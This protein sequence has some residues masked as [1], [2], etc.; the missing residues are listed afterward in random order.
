MPIEVD[1][2]S[3]DLARKK[4]LLLA[5]CER[6]GVITGAGYVLRI[7]SFYWCAMVVCNFFTFSIVATLFKIQQGLSYLQPR[8][9]EKVILLVL[10]LGHFPCPQRCVCKM[11]KLLHLLAINNTYPLLLR[12]VTFI[13]WLSWKS[14][15]V[16]SEAILIIFWRQCVWRWVH[17]LALYIHPWSTTWPSFWYLKSR[18]AFLLVKWAG[19]FWLRCH[20]LRLL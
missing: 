20:L 4:E 3:Y 1:R 12:C 13:N 17:K 8:I 6:T 9:L 15:R 18:Y 5:Q 10:I 19:Y 7:V 2:L 14:Y 16:Q 11:Y